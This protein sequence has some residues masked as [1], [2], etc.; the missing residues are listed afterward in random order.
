MSKNS[1]VT[2]REKGSWI[3][4]NEPKTIKIE[5]EATNVITK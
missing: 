1:S 5:S 4:T 3:K 2:P